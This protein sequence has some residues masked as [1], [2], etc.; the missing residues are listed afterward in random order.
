LCIVL[1]LT[2]INKEIS[3][4]DNNKY[5]EIFSL[6]KKLKVLNLKLEAKE[7]RYGDEIILF[8]Y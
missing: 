2:T 8:L 1:L 7:I 4:V 3:K 6:Y 5:I